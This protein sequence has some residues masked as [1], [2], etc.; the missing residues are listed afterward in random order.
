MGL[1]G[2]V[3]RHPSTTPSVYYVDADGDGYGAGNP[4]YVWPGQ[5]IAKTWVRNGGDCDDGNKTVFQTVDDLLPDCDLN[6]VADD[7]VPQSVCVGASDLFFWEDNAGL[8]ATVYYRDKAGDTWIPA[9]AA[10]LGPDGVPLVD[11]SPNCK[12]R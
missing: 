4:I 8:H 2:Q 5:P 7:L 9:S 6:G 3:R 11:S 10:R 1:S 12:N